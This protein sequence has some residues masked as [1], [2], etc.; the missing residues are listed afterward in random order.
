M[1][2]QFVFNWGQFTQMPLPTL[3]VI[4]PLDPVHDRLPQPRSRVPA[5]TVEDVLLQHGEERFHRRIVASSSDPTHRPDEPIMPYSVLEF[6]GTKLRP[7]VAVN[8]AT[9]H[10]SRPAATGHSI[11]DRRDRQARFHPRSDGVSDDSVAE[12]VLDRAHVEL[13]LIRVVLRNVGEPHFVD[14]ACGEVA[15]DEV[16]TDR[17]AGLLAVFSGSFDRVGEQLLLRAQSPHTS[18]RRPV[19]GSME[20]IG[21]EPVSELRIVRMD[22]VGGIE[23]VCLVP[24]PVRDRTCTPLVEPLLRKAE[25][26]AGHCHRDT[27]GSKV[28]VPAGTSLWVVTTELQVRLREIRCGLAE[29]LVLPLKLADALE[30]CC[31]GAGLVRVM[32]G[33]KAVLTQ[34]CITHPGLQG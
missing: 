28:T 9:G 7:A 10:G 5:T 4:G 30:R 2:N 21:D 12:H 34:T 33:L 17:R 22:V 16:I 15:F 6:S 11:L 25:H 29:D 24:V 32:R 27:G 3:P 19:A 13:A 26:P 18:L 1:V 14:P 20:F 8:E 23:Q 31:L